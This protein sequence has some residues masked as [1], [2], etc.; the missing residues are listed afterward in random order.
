M[1]QPSE[2]AFAKKLAYL[3]SKGI[4]N[5]LSRA[6]KSDEQDFSHEMTG[7]ILLP[8]AYQGWDK[9]L[10]PMSDPSTYFFQQSRPKE[11]PV[12]GCK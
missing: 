4:R 5:P 7:I 3:P 1:N 8:Q 6:A 12:R 11:P 2:M 10:K 9:D